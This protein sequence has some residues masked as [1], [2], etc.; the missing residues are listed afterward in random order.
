MLS[1]SEGNPIHVSWDAC[2]WDRSLNRQR[3]IGRAAEA[4]MW[5]LGET[6]PFL[7]REET[8]AVLKISSLLAVY[9]LVACQMENGQAVPLR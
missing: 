8:M 6:E 4:A 7:Q 1:P 5:L 9:A 3:G 2:R